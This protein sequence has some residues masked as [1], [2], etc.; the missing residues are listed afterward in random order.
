MEKR[1]KQW[2]RMLTSGFLHAN[3]IHLAINMFV[4]YQFGGIVENLFIA[5]FGEV[6]GRVNY[7]L[8][9]SLTIIAADLPTYYKHKNNPQFASIGASGA[10]SGIVFVYILFYP[11][12]KLY[13]WAVIPIYGI[14]A[15]IAFLWY[16]S[17][18]SKQN[19][20]FID[21]EAHFYGAV[22]GFLFTIA[23]KPSLA[24]LFFDRLTDLP[25]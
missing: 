14:I 5:P 1:E 8:L 7:I 3:W 23:L 18:A 4:L 19:R 24:L 16:S 11:W 25:F 10:V 22:F 21:H 20:D 12:A 6:M 15:G 17:Y 9:Y 2:Y 13:L